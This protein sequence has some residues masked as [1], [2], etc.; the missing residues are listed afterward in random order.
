LQAARDSTMGEIADENVQ[1]MEISADKNICVQSQNVHISQQTKAK[2]FTK[3]Y[4]A[5]L[6]F[7]KELHTI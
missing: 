5:I 7:K 1:F 3:Q 2:L 6:P 4:L